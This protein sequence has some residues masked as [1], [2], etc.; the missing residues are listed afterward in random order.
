MPIHKDETHK[1]GSHQK[2]PKILKSVDSITSFHH[3][4]FWVS[5]FT[6]KLFSCKCHLCEEAI[7][8]CSLITRWRAV[9]IMSLRS[10]YQGLVY[11]VK[12]PE[13]FLKGSIIII[14]I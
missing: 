8:F 10:K 9:S 4:R 12:C 14:N 13:L 7:E 5:L 11:S 6:K 3:I 2:S 1:N